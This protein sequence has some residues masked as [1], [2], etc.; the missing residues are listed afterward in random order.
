[1]RIVVIVI[2]VIVIVMMLAMAVLDLQTKLYAISPGELRS[3]SRSVSNVVDFK[4][5]APVDD[6]KH[7][8]VGERNQNG[9]MPYIV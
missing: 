2:P 6:A 8:E 5:A 7:V 1:L 9:H 3:F 4:T